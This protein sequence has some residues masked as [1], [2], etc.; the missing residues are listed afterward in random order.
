MGRMSSIQVYFGFLEF[1]N[2]A[3]PL[4]YICVLHGLIQDLISTS[5]SPRAEIAQ[6]GR[7]AVRS[8]C[9]VNN[10]TIEG[11]YNQSLQFLL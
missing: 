7:R 1:F 5:Q 4:T 8:Q 3:K 11:N 10:V 9:L 6:R 2:F